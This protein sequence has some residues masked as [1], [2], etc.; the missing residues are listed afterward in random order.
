MAAIV[1]ITATERERE[2]DERK[3]AGDNLFSIPSHPAS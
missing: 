2:K 1:N 3:C